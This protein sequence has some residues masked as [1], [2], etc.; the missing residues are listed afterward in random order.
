VGSP[1][2][3]QTCSHCAL[4]LGPD[5]EVVSAQSDPEL[6]FCCPGCAAAHDLVAGLGLDQYY[7]RRVLDEDAR[8]IKPDDSQAGLDFSLYVE[9]KEKAGSAKS[10]LS[11]VV[12]GFQCAAC[13]WLIEQVLSRDPRVAW[14]RVNMTTQRLNV[15]WDGSPELANDILD[16]IL[17][18]GY[19][20]FPFDVERV[21]ADRVAR[22]TDLL[23]SLGVAG[24]AA[25]NVMLLSVAIWAGYSQGMGPATRSLMHWVSALI[26]LPAVVYAGRPFFR[27]ALTALLAGRVNMDVPISLA[28]I[29]T[30]AMSLFQVISGADYAYFDSAVGLLFFLL[31]GRYLDSRARSRARSSAA[32]LLA[33]TARPV[34]VLQPDGSTV[35]LRPDAVEPGMLVMIAAGE[36]ISV[37]GTIEQG[38][39]EVDQSLLTGET[40]P[41][42]VE[43]GSLVY[44]G[45][46]NIGHALQIRV[47]ASS[48]NT[49]LAEIVRLLEQAEEGRARHVELAERISSWYAPVVHTLG[50]ATLLGWLIIGAPWQSALQYA[51]AVLIITCPCALALAVPA[52]QVVAAGRLMR[53][54]ILLKSATAL[55]RLAE[56]DTIA[57]D[58]TGTLTIGRPVL[59]GDYPVEDLGAA[60]RLAMASRHPLSRA[61]VQAAQLS[62]LSFGYQQLQNIEE[63]AGGGLEATFEGATWKLGSHQFCELP[64]EQALE[65]DGFSGPGIWFVRDG[66][67]PVHF[68]FEDEMRPDASSVTVD[69]QQQG[70]D[71]SILSGDRS[72]VVDALAVR[73]K[74]G[75]RYAGLSPAEKFNWLLEKEK[76]GRQVLMVGDGLNDA[77]ALAAAHV[78]LSPATAADISQAASDAVFQGD[79]LRPVAEI[80]DVAKRAKTV[81]W[82]NIIF[83]FVYNA[84]CIPFAV[85]G[86]VTPLFA[87]VA[88]SLSSLIVLTNSLRLGKI[89]PSRSNL[90]YNRPTTPS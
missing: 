29:L 76:S 28:V 39:S 69:L 27:S 81:I 50:L 18:L 36:R 37:D 40:L 13:G 23:K 1:A 5:I 51:V 82:Q 34:N 48:S 11:L 12:D 53:R 2:S 74:V 87:A 46:L 3:G 47:T 35:S 62:G 31:I 20:L 67:H 25:A 71:L 73:L 30:S 33:L 4:P 57:F 43:K 60:A 89:Q 75:S 79:R 64:D 32:H 85:A 15:T 59:V 58:K 49:A 42:S 83:A 10:S 55:E 22:E 56:V 78:S 65:V 45:T 7:Q 24:F 26:A 61:L 14:G 68:H 52:V 38:T 8:R 66:H 21:E 77:P 72:T 19:R 80:L 86:L 6:K 44:A 54:G 63:V 90:V 16:P 41:V 88:M 17:K 70:Y 84:V 9:S